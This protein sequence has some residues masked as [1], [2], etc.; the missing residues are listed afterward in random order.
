MFLSLQI[1]K[2][3]FALYLMAGG[4]RYVQLRKGEINE[5]LKIWPR[6]G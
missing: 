6:A 4:G 2:G 1:S 3:V 5:A